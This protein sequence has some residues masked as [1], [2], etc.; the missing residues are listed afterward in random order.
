MK[1]IGIFL[2]SR[3]RLQ[4]LDRLT[5]G[6]N[7]DE[8]NIGISAQEVYLVG[9]DQI[10]EIYEVLNW[11]NLAGRQYDTIIVEDT[12]TSEEL[13]Y[14]NIYLKPQG[15]MELAPIDRLI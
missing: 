12:L 1:R 9:N 3:C 2:A 15:T 8:Y 10:I 6:L 5:K 7:L 14:F 13:G 11:K 4:V